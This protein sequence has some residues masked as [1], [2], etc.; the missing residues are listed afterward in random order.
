MM[1]K[2]NQVP[3][4]DV[5]YTLSMDERQAKML[6]TACEFYARVNMGQWLEVFH[7]CADLRRTDYSE[8]RDA[9]EQ[10]L[11]QAR[12]IV[13]PELHGAGHSFGVGKFEH[14]DIVW[15]I[16]EVLRNRI[17]WTE[18]PEGGIGVSF[19]K[20]MSF[21]GRNL[22]ICTSVVY[23]RHCKAFNCDKRHGNYCCNDCGMR[24]GCKNPCQNA[25]ERCGLAMAPTKKE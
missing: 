14:A 5:R 24:S 1:A 19:S 7:S 11:L 8:A 15:E 2:K 21:S 23:G 13:W 17:A 16:Y 12:Q 9:V 6:A 22:P 4:K 20:P 25:P 18:H 3:K 10:L